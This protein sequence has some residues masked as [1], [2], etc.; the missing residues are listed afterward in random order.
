[1]LSLA[2]LAPVLAAGGITDL[3]PGLTLWTGITF[4][5]LLVVLSKFAWGPIVKM[6]AERERTIKD[7][8]E[9]AKR[10]RQEA[11]RLLGEQKD[12]LVRAQREAAEIARRNQQEVESL[13]Q[14]LTA[15]ARKEADELVATARQQIAEE[16]SKAR[17]ELKAQVADLAIDAAGRLVK[18]NLDEKA[19]RKL[20]EEYIAQLPANRAA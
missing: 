17:A 15:R 4:L 16:L 10:E 14:E 2:P 5:V 6:L 1:M 8:I 18:A 11:E 13:R 20:V 7:A 9:A 3:N 19:Q 12:G